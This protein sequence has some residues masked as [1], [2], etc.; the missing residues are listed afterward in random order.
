MDPEQ[1]P[2]GWVEKLRYLTP[3][4][5]VESLRWYCCGP[6]KDIPEGGWFESPGRS[7]I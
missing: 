5:A 3:I 4:I 2:V 6:F 1:V 7:E